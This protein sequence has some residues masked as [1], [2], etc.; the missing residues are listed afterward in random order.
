MLYR[1]R[2]GT[3]EVY[4]FRATYTVLIPK[5]IGGNR[6]SGVQT[7]IV[8]EIRTG[9]AVDKDVFEQTL[10]NTNYDYKDLVYEE[11][12]LTDEQLAR[13]A[14]CRNLPSHAIR[15]C[16]KYVLDGT[17]PQEIDHELRKLQLSKENA[18]LGQQVSEGEINEIMM[19]VMVSD[20]EIQLLEMQMLLSELGGEPT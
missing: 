9:Y 10:K 15:D 7:E 1:H 3:F 17:F 20:L 5:V 18:L 6:S 13:Y 12:T 8:E 2:Q 4:P 16:N 19:G 11:I 14:E